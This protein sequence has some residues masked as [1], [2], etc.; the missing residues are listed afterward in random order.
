MN[1]LIVIQEAIAVTGTAQN[2]PNNPVNK[3]VTIH[4]SST[5]TAAL[6]FGNSAAVVAS[7]GFVLEADTTSGVGQSVTIDLAGGNT[8]QLW[9][10]G[11]SG[12][13]FSVI[14]A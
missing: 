11:T 9:V 5:N 1:N 3:S 10:I 4:A 12:D 6:V 7:T 13:K 14:G 8:D 2:L